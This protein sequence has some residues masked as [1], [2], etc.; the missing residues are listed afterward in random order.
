MILS[1]LDK[2]AVFM[3]INWY[4]HIKYYAEA[5][6]LKTWKF[7]AH[8]QNM[9]FFYEL[10]FF[11]FYMRLYDYA[12]NDTGSI[13]LF[14]SLRLFLGIWLS[15]PISVFMHKLIVC[16]LSALF[17]YCWFN[18]FMYILLIFYLYAKRSIEI[19]LAHLSR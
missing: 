17:V 10:Y 2:Y 14:C 19:F 8:N 4:R 9:F 3:R 18:E 1:K 5:A 16:V 12:N 11:F 13:I 6:L 15:N 7:A